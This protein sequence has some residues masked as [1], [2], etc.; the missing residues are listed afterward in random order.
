M[1]GLTGELSR[2][3]GGS[4]CAAVFTALV[5]AD[6]VLV[7]VSGLRLASSA[8]A[9][10]L[11]SA[12]LAAGGWPWARLALFGADRTLAA[13]LWAARVPSAVPLAPDEATARRLL[14]VRPPFV[15]RRLDLPEAPS[16]AHRARLF[17]GSACDDWDPA[18]DH[19]SA[20]Q[21]HDDAVMVV[22]EL[23]TNAVTHARTGCRV[24][25][26]LAG[27]RLEIAVRDYRRNWTTSG[28]P[29][30]APRGEWRGLSLVAALSRE[31]GVSPADGGKVVWAVLPPAP[32]A[33]RGTGHG[34]ASRSGRSEGGPTRP[35]RLVP[36]AGTGRPSQRGTAPGKA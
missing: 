9:Q 17:V 11:P 20:A 31:W 13:A 3:S 24:A 8:A 6:R 12:L 34:G 36:V 25:V 4:A 35:R 1:L 22:N 10:V 7:D 23:V 32:A 29:A 14:D 2:R 19:P 27:S 28:H 5:G 30:T 21:L 33:V 18:H 26:Q 16:S 15:A